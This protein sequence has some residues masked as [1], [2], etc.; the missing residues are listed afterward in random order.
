MEYNTKREQFIKELRVNQDTL[1]NVFSHKYSS[2]LHD[3]VGSLEIFSNP[4]LRIKERL[5]PAAKPC[6]D[7]QFGCPGAQ[8]PGGSRLVSSGQVTGWIRGKVTLP[9]RRSE[10]R[11][12]SHRRW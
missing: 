2:D 9:V 7:T 10:P 3:A 8:G 12:A 5:P 11:S 1:D 6:L 4:A